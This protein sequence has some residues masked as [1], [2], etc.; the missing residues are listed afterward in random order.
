VGIHFQLLITKLHHAMAMGLFFS[1]FAL[2]RRYE[3][4][5][6]G[7]VVLASIYIMEEH[8]LGI[9]IDCALTY[10]RVMSM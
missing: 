1:T 10:H 5:V 8:Y 6:Q 7:N 2:S 3:V 4:N 9:M